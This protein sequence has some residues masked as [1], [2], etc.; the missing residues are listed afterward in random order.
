MKYTGNKS[1]PILFFM[2]YKFLFY[3]LMGPETKG[4]DRGMFS[5]ASRSMCNMMVVLK[6]ALK[7]S[8]VL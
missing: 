2:F 3:F 1:L 6:T 8:F 7:M 4:W 5:I